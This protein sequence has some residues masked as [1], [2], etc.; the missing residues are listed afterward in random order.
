MEQSMAETRLTQLRNSLTAL[1]RSMLDRAWASLVERGKPISTRAFFH[2]H[3]RDQA[4]PALDAL[5]G[6]IIIEHYVEGVS[7]FSPTLLGALLSSGG[8]HL[9]DILCRCLQF[10]RDQYEVQPELHSHSSEQLQRIGAFESPEVEELRLMLS[11]AYHTLVVFGGGG[12]PGGSWTLLVRDEVDQLRQVKHWHE[13]VHS[14]VM[15][16]FDPSFPVS[17]AK[18]AVFE[19]PHWKLLDTPSQPNIDEYATNQEGETLRFE[20]ITDEK[21]RNIITADW[22][23][24]LRVLHI[25]AWKACIM[26]CGG[27]L[28]GMFLTLAR[29]IPE[30]EVEQTVRQLKLRNLSLSLDERG[31][32]DLQKICEH[33]NL[34]DPERTHLSQFIRAYRNLIH[35]GL[36]SRKNVT[37][38]Q[39][40]ALIAVNAVRSIARTIADQSS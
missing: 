36:Q 3:P 18:R 30:G 6:K 27:I 1:Q 14:A 19:L 21:L 13:Y 5:G 4:V 38:H 29:R 32:A 11:L 16:K 17:E 35:P 31:L 34:L 22:S 10:V 20:F 25:G 8:Q 39:E 26:L 7:S 40:D 2:A 9:E 12:Q 15:E 23:E 24:A 28:E 33:K 37:V